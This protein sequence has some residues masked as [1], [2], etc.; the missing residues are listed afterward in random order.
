MSV[1]AQ[2]QLLSGSNTFFLNGIHV[3]FHQDNLANKAVE[4]GGDCVQELIQRNLN[5]LHLKLKSTNSLLELLPQSLIGLL[6]LGR[7]H[8]QLGAADVGH[9]LLLDVDVVVAGPFIHNFNVRMLVFHNFVLD[10]AIVP[11][12]RVILNLPVDLRVLREDLS[13]QEFLRERESLYF[14]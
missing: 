12:A 14:G 6:V 1:F 8:N 13:Q 3:F 5:F 7:L 9:S 11:V 2:L 10:S 4:I